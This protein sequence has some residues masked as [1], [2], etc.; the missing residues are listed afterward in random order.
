MNTL[1]FSPGNTQEIRNQIS[2]SVVSIKCISRKL[3][4][5]II[6]FKLRDLVDLP[7]ARPAVRNSYYLDIPQAE[8]TLCI[9]NPHGAAQEVFLLSK[10]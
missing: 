10:F 3:N 8:V 5:Q 9:V 1:T 4:L 2:Y 6:R 7:R